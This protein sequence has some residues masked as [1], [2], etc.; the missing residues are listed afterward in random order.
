M[1]PNEPNP[2]I[3]P[4][5][6]SAFFSGEQVTTEPSPVT[7]S[8]STTLS[9]WE[10]YL[11]DAT[12]IPAIDNVPPTVTPRLFVNTGGTR[13]RFARWCVSSRQTT[14]GSTSTVRFFSSTSPMRFIDS[15][16]RSTPSW[17]MASWDCEWAE[18]RLVRCSVF[19]RQKATRATMSFCDCG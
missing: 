4:Q 11:N 2:A 15:I 18:P 17:L 12:P 19:D 9:P 14:P 16:S 6:R 3:A 10:P 5:N 7:T 8:S 13:F 1:T